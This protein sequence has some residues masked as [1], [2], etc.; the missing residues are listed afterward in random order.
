M[1]GESRPGDAGTERWAKPGARVA[2]GSS[3]LRAGPSSCHGDEPNKGSRRGG[4][5]KKKLG[6]REGARSASR[7]GG[8]KPSRGGRWARQERRTP[9]ESSVGIFLRAGAAQEIR[10]REMSA[11]ATSR[12]RSVEKIQEKKNLHG[13]GIFLELGGKAAIRIGLGDLV[14]V[15]QIFFN[16]P[17]FLFLEIADIFTITI[18]SN[19]KWVNSNCDIVLI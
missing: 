11:L 1:V 7:E 10:L 14:L 12:V 2:P 3:R 18:F 19:V 6:C 13:S 9:G 8:G 4:L 17:S 5:W 16:F 15:F